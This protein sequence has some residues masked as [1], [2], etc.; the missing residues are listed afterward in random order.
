MS[1]MFSLRRVTLHLLRDEKDNDVASVR[2]R[3]MTIFRSMERMIKSAL[4]RLH[5]QRK[6]QDDRRSLVLIIELPDGQMVETIE[7]SSFPSE[8]GSQ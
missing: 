3:Y 5:E 1:T 2:V 6:A 4:R 8:G 7:I